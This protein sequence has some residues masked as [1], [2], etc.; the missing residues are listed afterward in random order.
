M[1]KLR[2]DVYHVGRRFDV[3]ENFKKLLEQIRQG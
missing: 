2:I 3:Y 1:D